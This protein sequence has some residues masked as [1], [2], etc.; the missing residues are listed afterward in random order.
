[1]R[2][3]LFLAVLTACGPRA[4]FTP[5]EPL[6][7]PAW[8]TTPPPAAPERLQAIFPLAAGDRWTWDVER[9]DRRHGRFLLFI[10][11]NAVERDTVGTWT[12]TVDTPDP[13][14][15]FPATL[16]RSGPGDPTTRSLT[17]W[18]TDEGLWMRDGDREGPA[19]VVHPPA[20][21]VRG[22]V[23]P[24]E[25]PFLGV[26]AS[27]HAIPGG[28][29]GYPPGPL[30]ADLA[31]WGHTDGADVTLMLLTGFVL[32]P[33]GRTTEQLLTLRDH[34][35]VPTDGPPLPLTEAVAE[36][37]TGFLRAS[38][39]TALK[40]WLLRDDRA[41]LT[42]ED[43]IGALQHAPTDGAV[44]ALVE[45]LGPEARLPLTR[46]RLRALEGDVARLR[47]LAA[48]LDALPDLTDAD[49]FHLVLCLQE[50]WGRRQA[51]RLLAGNTEVLAVYRGERTWPEVARATTDPIT[52]RAFL[53]AVEDE[54]V[55]RETT[56]AMLDAVD[57]QER[58]SLLRYALWV[59]PE[60]RLSLLL[61]GQ[62]WVSTLEPG[63]QGEIVSLFEGGDRRRV[64]K[65][66]KGR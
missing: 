63:F 25:V 62:P 28:S 31:S 35:A 64:K 1:M 16:A 38:R 5:P 40:R 52:R 44:Q 60:D 53:D 51:T 34:P 3:L 24:C 7:R 30:R 41:E 47:A 22:E 49:R 4:T 45:V 58:A 43:A 50:P 17:L 59:R 6:A 39:S 42:L 66:L 55:R 26:E 27:C 15:R 48:A 36:H 65:A 11:T 32:M 9:V 21:A 37:R 10:P 12:L 14:G 57:T 56:L 29:A 61:S 2:A 8:R 23:L 18:H 13:A 54:V 33:L 20:D 46:A 19:L